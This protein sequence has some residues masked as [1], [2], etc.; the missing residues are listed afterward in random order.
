MH[1]EIGKFPFHQVI[2]IYLVKFYPWEKRKGTLAGVHWD[3][4]TVQVGDCWVKVGLDLFGSNWKHFSSFKVGR[5]CQG[6]AF[7]GEG[8]FPLCNS[9]PLTHAQMMP[10]CPASLLCLSL[11]FSITVI[12]PKFPELSFL[13]AQTLISI[14]FILV[15]PCEQ[16]IGRVGAAT[17]D[18]EGWDG[19]DWSSGSVSDILV[20]RSC[21]LWSRIKFVSVFRHDLHKII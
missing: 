18:W 15:F 4:R 2:I 21:H 5:R 6:S 9:A 20:C 7:W 12:N 19:I 10:R 17:V 8:Y 11:S 1:M 3:V 14:L 13:Q 16:F